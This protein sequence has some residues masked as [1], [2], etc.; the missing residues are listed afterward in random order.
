MSLRI[1]KAKVESVLYTQHLM[2]EGEVYILEGERFTD[3]MNAEP[4]FQTRHDFM[5]VTNSKVYSL[6]EDRLLYETPFLNVNKDFIVVAF[7]KNLA[8]V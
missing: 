4:R 8:G 7:P 6:S 5:P 3:F 2:I 1:E